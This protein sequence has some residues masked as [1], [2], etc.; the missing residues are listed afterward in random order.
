MDDHLEK[1]NTANWLAS[2]G[3]TCR[4]GAALVAEGRNPDFFCSGA[5]EMWVE[6]KALGEKAHDRALGLAF[7]DIRERA[8]GTKGTGRA[9]AYISPQATSSDIKV[10]L[11]LVARQAN[12]N[13]ADEV[14]IVVPE[15]PVPGNYVAFRY[16]S[17]GR[18][19]EVVSVESATG[20]YGL[21]HGA[22]PDIG[23]E[24]RQEVEFRHSRKGSSRSK[25]RHL[26]TLT[27]DVLVALSITPSAEPFG[28]Y[29]CMALEWQDHSTMIRQSEARCTTRIARFG[30][31]ASLRKRP[32]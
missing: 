25:L 17:A 13:A 24:L 11:N 32:D 31:R 12:Q 30:M 3:V 19:Y 22:I 21:P 2:R 1:Q 14:I 8:I 9:F 15:K 29:A 6:I 5:L 23:E 27:D 10:A 18:V 26:L 28:V 16:S 20:Y 4:P 7:A